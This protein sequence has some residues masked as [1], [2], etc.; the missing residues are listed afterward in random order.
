M[1]KKIVNDN[2]RIIVWGLEFIIIPI[3]IF[4]ILF[5]LMII[6]PDACWMGKCYYG[7]FFILVA[8]AAIGD[9][10]VIL[11][12]GICVR[13]NEMRKNLRNI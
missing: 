8:L 7:I 10:I 11:I 2:N 13:K 4:I 5:I 3:I 6:F 1:N 9:G 12:I